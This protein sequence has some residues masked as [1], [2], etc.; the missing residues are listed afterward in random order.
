LQDNKV[1]LSDLD[2]I[3]GRGGLLKPVQSGVFAINE[4]MLY[5]LEN[6]GIRGE[7]ASN[8]GAV[9]ANALA[10]ESGK[11]IPTYIADP[12]VVDEMSILAHYSGHPLLPHVAIWHPLNQK[13]TIRRFVKDHNLKYDELN[14]IGVH[15]GGGVSVAMHQKGKVVDVNNAWNGDGPMTPE[16]AGTLPAAALVELCFS[17]R[18]QRTDLLKMVSGRGGAVAHLGTNDFREVEEQALEKGNAKHKEFLDA[19]IYHVAKQIG[20][21]APITSGQIDYIVITGGIAHSKYITDEIAKRV[22][23]LAPVYVYPGEDE[24]AALSENA[25]YATIGEREVLEYK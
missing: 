20:F 17:G 16:R 3:I 23:F 4:A 7:H 19:F 11:K 8:L 6:T 5:D 15:L 10:K 12:V 22:K 18:Y 2:V 25:Y 14:I 1:A 9:I 21:V 24:M 13:S